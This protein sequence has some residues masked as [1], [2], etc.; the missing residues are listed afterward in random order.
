MRYSNLA[1]LAV[2][3]LLGCGVSDSGGDGTACESEYPPPAALDAAYTACEVD[4]DCLVLELG[5]CDQCNGGEAVAVNGDSELDVAD[6]Y[7]QCV[8]DTGNWACTAMACTP[9]TATCDAGVCTMHR[10]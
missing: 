8:P 1:V 10:D 3:A 6:R 7:A 2:F 9:P 4:D 5:I